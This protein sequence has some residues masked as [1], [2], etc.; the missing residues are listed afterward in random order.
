M[1]R[2]RVELIYIF[3]VKKKGASEFSE[4]AGIHRS[5]K[6]FWTPELFLNA[7]QHFKNVLRMKSEI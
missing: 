7:T 4:A 2:P 1:L 3:L 6:T 5:L